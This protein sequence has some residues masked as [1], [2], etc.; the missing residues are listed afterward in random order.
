MI[1][2]K[3]TIQLR[4][5]FVRE[6]VVDLVR[7]K[8]LDVRVDLIISFVEDIVRY[9]EEE[10]DE[11]ETNQYLIGM[12][13]LFRGYVVAMWEGTNVNSK[14]FKT[15]NKIVVKRCVE[16]YVKCWKHRNEAYND[17]EKQK[18][19]MKKWYKKE[20]RNAENSEYEQIREYARKFK[21]NEERYSSETI[22]TWIKNLKVIE[23]KMEDVPKND[24][25]RY[26]GSREV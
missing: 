5:E 10:E 18:E 2:C 25:R 1:K 4:R 21:I 9:L 7:N 26:M 14:K 3:E 11:Y 19:R 6:L 17:E 16:H 24:I 15:M 23:K 12:K 20:L 8:P 22:K 13:E